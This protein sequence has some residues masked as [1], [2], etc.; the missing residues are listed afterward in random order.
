MSISDALVLLFVCLLQRIKPRSSFSDALCFSCVCAVLTELNPDLHFSCSMFL[1]FVWLL[2]TRKSWHTHV[3]L[4]FQMLFL[5]LGNPVLHFSTFQQ[6]CLFSKAANT[7]M[8]IFNT[9]HWNNRWGKIAFRGVHLAHVCQVKA[10]Q[11]VYFRNP[12]G[13]TWKNISERTSGMTRQ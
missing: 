8:V 13:G 9:K 12:S 5:C 2:D 11:V 7:I 4:H 6:N 1:L 3:A 10:S